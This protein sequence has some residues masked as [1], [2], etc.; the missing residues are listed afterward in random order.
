MDWLIV[1]WLTVDV[2]G[3]CQEEVLNEVPPTYFLAKS[4]AG[5]AV[6]RCVS[7]RPL[8]RREL[9]VPPS[10]PTYFLAK[11]EVSLAVRRFASPLPLLRRPP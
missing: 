6:R 10:P 11:L 5:L 7:S 1:A 9:W 4:E 3:T 8:L 2:N